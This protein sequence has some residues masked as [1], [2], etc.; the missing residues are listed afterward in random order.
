[1]TFVR[2]GTAEGCRKEGKL[3]GGRVNAVGKGEW[4]MSGQAKT[5]SVVRELS[6]AIF[7]LLEGN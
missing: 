3:N 7:V 6:T 4:Q 5:R 1:M 2:P